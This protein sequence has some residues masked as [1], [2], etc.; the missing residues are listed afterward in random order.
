MN[1][2]ES[3][4][5]ASV[6]SISGKATDRTKD[7]AP[8]RSEKP[9]P[10]TL[11]ETKEMDQRRVSIKRLVVGEPTR[12]ATADVRF[13]PTFSA[14]AKELPT[15]GDVETIELGRNDSIDE[16]ILIRSKRPLLIRN[17]EGVQPTILFRPKSYSSAAAALLRVVGGDVSVQGIHCEWQSAAD[18]VNLGQCSN[19][20]W[21]G[22][23]LLP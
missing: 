18:R 9:D 21:R 10:G 7:V 1:Q 19:W 16:S 23:A 5:I 6:P 20:K 3:S 15:L 17:A 11:S 22:R 8:P 4:A 2:T 12:D 13:F 14:A